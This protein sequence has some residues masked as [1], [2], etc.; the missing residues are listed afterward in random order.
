MGMV[1]AA[2][3]GFGVEVGG[4]GVGVVGVA[5]EVDDGVAELFVDGPAERDD[6]DFAGLAG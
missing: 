2:G 1:V 5:G 3:S 4:P 6:F